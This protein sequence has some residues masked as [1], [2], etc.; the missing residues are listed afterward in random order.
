MRRS[1]IA[2][3]MILASTV[4]L[5]ISGSLSHGFAQVGGPQGDEFNSSTFQAPFHAVCG[6]SAAKPCPDPAGTGTWSVN[7]ESPGNLRIWTQFGSLVGGPTQASN[8]ARNMILQPVDPNVDW[9]A[10]TKMTFPAAASTS[11]PLALGQTAGLLVYQD[12]DNFIYVGQD[13]VLGGAPQLEF[14][15]EIAGND[16]RTAVPLTGVPP[17]T[18]YLRLQKSGT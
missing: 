6:A 15:Q 1:L 7:S 18:I 8:T 4:A 9:T 12:D 3:T 11:S 10:T 16:Y 13:F 14:L 2:T 17:Q 5:A